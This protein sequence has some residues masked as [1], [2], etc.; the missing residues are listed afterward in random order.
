MY[1]KKIP[2]FPMNK[3]NS[4]DECFDEREREDMGVVRGVRN[5]KTCW[6]RRGSEFWNEEDE[7]GKGM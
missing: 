5:D 3:T 1:G 2:S 7:N 4:K 6:L